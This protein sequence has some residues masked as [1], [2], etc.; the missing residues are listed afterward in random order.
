MANTSPNAKEVAGVAARFHPGPD[1]GVGGRSMASPGAKARRRRGG[2]ADG[3]GARRNGGDGLRRVP[4]GPTTSTNAAVTRSHLT[5]WTGSQFVASHTAAGS[6]SGPQ[7]TTSIVGGEVGTR[8]N[9]GG[10]SGPLFQP[11]AS[12]TVAGAG[13]L[14]ATTA[15]R[16]AGRSSGGAAY[17]VRDVV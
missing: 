7:L 3:G 5:H 4:A 6:E 17:T 1:L 2:G 14:R 11:R 10:G 8:H 12:D 13:A 9:G 15:G 16:K